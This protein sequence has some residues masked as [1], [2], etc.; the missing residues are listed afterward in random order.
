MSKRRGRAGRSAGGSRGAPAWLVTASGTDDAG[1]EQASVNWGGPAQTLA[2]ATTVTFQPVVIPEAV[3]A[4]N[5]PPSIGQCDIVGLDATIDITSVSAAGLYTV[6]VGLYVS[7]FSTKTAQWELREPTDAGDAGDQDF[8]HLVC[9]AFAAQ[10]AAAETGPVS[11]QLRA[12]LPFPI[13]IGAGQA[14][15]LTLDNSANSPGIITFVPFIRA[16]ISHVA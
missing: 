5:A 16:K 8:L 1:A 14:L 11:I 6:G 12:M 7:N 3:T 2:A 10:L 15:H 4:N 9:H 13:R